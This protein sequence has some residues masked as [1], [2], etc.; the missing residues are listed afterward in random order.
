MLQVVSQAIQVLEAVA[1]ISAHTVADDD[2]GSHIE[3]HIPDAQEVAEAIEK[4]KTASIGSIV[5]K[6]VHGTAKLHVI[7]SNSGAEA[8]QRVKKPIMSA[9]RLGIAFVLEQPADATLPQDVQQ[10]GPQQQQEHHQQQQQQQGLAAP[11]AAPVANTYSDTRL[12]GVIVVWSD[13]QGAWLRTN[14]SAATLEL[15]IA[16]MKM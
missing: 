12:Y 9:S 3:G 4:A 8:V 10:N 11:V 6:R 7:N 1:A 2:D 5:T 16:A 13:T 15:D 14:T